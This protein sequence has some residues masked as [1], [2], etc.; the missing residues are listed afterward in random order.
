MEKYNEIL[1]EILDFGK[2]KKNRTG[3][4]TIGLFSRTFRHD[5]SE[6][7]PLLGVRYIPF[8]SIKVELE[9]FLRGQTSKKWYQDRGCKYWNEWCSPKKVP[10]SHDAETLA[11]MAAEDDLGPI[12]GA[13]W[14]NFG[15]VDQLSQIVRK[16]KSTPDDRRM[17]CSAW[18]P[19]EIPDMA[20]PPCHVL[21]YVSV[22]DGA[23]NL[24]WWQ[25]SCDFVLGAPSNIASYA[26]LLHLLARDANLKEGEL[27][28]HFEDV[29][30]YENHMDASKKIL[31][32]PIPPLP[33]IKTFGP[34]S[35]FEWTE[36]N[37][38]LEN[39]EH[40]PKMKLKVAI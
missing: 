32:L 16:L 24:S 15:G 1:Q 36:K 14:R 20:L 6:G 12:Y 22:A 37:T 35:I 40:G 31:S 7:F 13:Q 17:V 5:M 23:L 3:T 29:H 19:P 11:K 30:V 9:G 27:V 4:N 18:N 26:L 8:S 25:R 10:Y 34:K 39:Y 2:L 28:G 38:V 33:T 21:W